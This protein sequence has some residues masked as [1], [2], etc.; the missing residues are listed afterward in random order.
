MVSRKSI[1]DKLLGFL[2]AIERGEI[3]L[4]PNDRRPMDFVLCE[5]KASNGWTICIFNDCGEWDYIE[6][7]QA[8]GRRYS[9]HYLAKHCPKTADYAPPEEAIQNIY[10]L[11]LG[12]RYYG[13][14][15]P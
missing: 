3:K 2:K 9:Y 11:G 4:V 6:W 13:G 1:D 12:G 7:I 5:Y 15:N 14:E 8:G 10:L